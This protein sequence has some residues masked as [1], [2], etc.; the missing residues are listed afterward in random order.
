MEGYKIAGKTGTAEKVGRDK[1][2]YVV[3]FCG[4]APADNPQV[5]VYVVV[6]EP[7]VEE[8]AH[9]TYASKIF[10]KIMTEILP[11]LNIFP[12]TDI[13]P[14]LPEGGQAEL[15]SEEGIT[16]STEGSSEESTEE[17]TEAGTLEN[18]ETI[19]PEA[20]DPSEEAVIGP[21][22]EAGYG[23]PGALPGQTNPVRLPQTSS[24]SAEASETETKGE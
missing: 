22:E 6:D 23:L 24:S 20:L 1:K 18:G 10:Q 16:S 8:Q 15:P 21:S 5:L 7:H 2:N 14:S 3:S 9:S 17:S 13:T 12:D 19:P 4:Y 11:Y